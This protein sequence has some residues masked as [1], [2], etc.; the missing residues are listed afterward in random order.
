MASIA[1]TPKISPFPGFAS[2]GI[3]CDALTRPLN[4]DLK[5][6]AKTLFEQVST[7]NQNGRQE[8]RVATDLMFLDATAQ[9]L[10]GNEVCAAIALSGPD[11]L[12]ATNQGTQD[13]RSVAWYT[14]ATVLEKRVILGGGQFLRLGFKCYIRSS[15]G[16]NSLEKSMGTVTYGFRG[17][18]KKATLVS[19][20]PNLEYHISEKEFP[21]LPDDE[22]TLK[23]QLYQELDSDYFQLLYSHDVNHVLK[24]WKPVVTCRGALSRRAAKILTNLSLIANGILRRNAWRPE[25][26]SPNVQHYARY[27][28]EKYAQYH[29]DHPEGNEDG[30]IASIQSECVGRFQLDMGGD[31][32]ATFLQAAREHFQEI[33]L[34]DNVSADLEQHD[35]W[36]TILNDS[37]SHELSRSDDFKDHICLTSKP[38]TGV[39]EMQQLYRDLIQSY[40][41]YKNSNSIKISSVRSIWD[42]L[43]TLKIDTFSLPDFVATKWDKFYALAR[44]YFVQL[45][46]IEEYVRKDAESNGSLANRLAEESIFKDPGITL[47][48]GEEGVHAE[49]RLF[50]YHLLKN[51]PRSKYYGI[52]KLCCALCKYTL[53]QFE[54][55]GFHPPVTR[56]THA[57][58]FTWPLPEFLQNNDHLKHF[59]GPQLFERYMSYGPRRLHSVNKG[60][61]YSSQDVCKALITRLD[62]INSLSNLKKL[63]IEGKW[64]IN[65]S[66]DHYADNYKPQKLPSEHPSAQYEAELETLSKSH[67]DLF[68]PD[69]FRSYLHLG[70]AWRKKGENRDA[71]YYLEKVA[72][73][74]DKFPNQMTSEEKGKLFTV[75]GNIYRCFSLYENALRFLTKVLQIRKSIYQPPHVSIA[76]TLYNLGLV[77]F[78]RGAFTQASSCF[79]EAQS[80]AIA[81]NAANLPNLIAKGLSEID[82]IIKSEDDHKTA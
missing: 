16:E 56:G 1:S 24:V 5:E 81:V 82:K 43:D 72:K 20:S 15:T 68:H 58:L 30:F 64:L 48:D 66:Q 9:L 25:N 34:A 60:P 50:S 21:Y 63:G 67:E 61:F 14:T 40:L 32:S 3:I 4:S 78:D 31:T 73:I 70:Y 36:V 27:I 7:A 80:Q 2:G 18:Q 62:G 69:F 10:T 74:I 41:S 42:W 47:V 19:G 8:K 55:G 45:M 76:T 53:E 71:V 22:I 75:L 12:I 23:L 57:A 33:R 35:R 44:R 28:E 11:I 37:L 77:Y 26:N 46:F 6:F 39:Q 79:R 52:A 17:D 49:M 59:F 54:A 13:R 65:G 38:P 51:N 29:Q